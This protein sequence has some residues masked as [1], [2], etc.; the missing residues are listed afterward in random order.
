MEEF[1]SEV[2]Q[3]TTNAR[4]VMV[5]RRASTVLK[6]SAGVLAVGSI[7]SAYLTATTDLNQ[8]YGGGP[9]PKFPF[10]VKLMQFLQTAVPNLGWAAL[11]YASAYALLIAAARLETHRAQPAAGADDPSPSTAPPPPSTTFVDVVT[12]NLSIPLV[13][14]D[15]SIWRP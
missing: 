5:V 1:G 10:K 15:D 4:V 13:S 3:P 6:V 9:S 8:Y 12:P 7:V 2:A 11:V 14:K